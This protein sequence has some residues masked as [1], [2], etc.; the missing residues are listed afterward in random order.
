M[1]PSSNK[2]VIKLCLQI[3]QQLLRDSGNHFIFEPLIFNTDLAEQYFINITLIGAKF[4]SVTF[5]WILCIEA[6]AQSTESP[7][8]YDQAIEYKDQIQLQWEQKIISC[9]DLCLKVV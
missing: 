6:W 9:I 7:K 4:S 2:L 8:S 3:I 1:D 5:N